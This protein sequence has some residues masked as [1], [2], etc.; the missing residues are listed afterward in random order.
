[1]LRVD[2]D[3]IDLKKLYVLGAW[4]LF[5][6]FYLISV[7]AHWNTLAGYLPLISQVGLDAVLSAL[8]YRLYREYHQSHVSMVY[9]LFLAS[10]ICAMFAD[11]IYH[12]AMNI[13]DINY[14]NRFNSLFEIP[15][16]LFLLFQAIVWLKIFFI[17]SDENVKKIAYLP[18]LTVSTFIFFTFVY[19]IPWE[20]HH[21]SR[22]GMYQL[23]DT[24]LEVIGFAFATLCLARSK[25]SPV[26]YLSIG[27]LFIIS[28]DLLI[29]YEVITGNIPFLN[30]FEMSWC[31]GL[32]MMVYGFYLLKKQQI[33]LLSLNSL[34]SHVA[35]WLINLMLLF[36][37]LFLLAHYFFPQKNISDYLLLVIIPCTFLA[38]IFS[39]Y[40]SSKI[41][42]PLARLEL[43]IKTFM[44][45]G[46]SKFSNA[47]V[48]SP[49]DIEDFILLE[50]FIHDSFQMYKKNQDI[51]MEF[52]NVATQVAHDIQSPMIALNNYLKDAV[53]LEK[54]KYAVVEAS[55]SRINE[56]ANNLL[57]QYKQSDNHFVED[58]NDIDR[59]VVFLNSLIEE[60]RLQFKDKPVE[61]KLTIDR[62]SEAAYVVFNAVSFKR[63]LSNLINNAVE[64]AANHAQIEISLTKKLEHLMLEIRDNGCG[65][66]EDILEDIKLNRA[67]R[68]AKGNGLGL[69]YA[70][71]SIKQWGAHYTIDSKQNLGTIFQIIWPIQSIP[72]W[73]QGD[74]YVH[75]HL[76]IVIVDDDQSVFK[77]WE[78][79]LGDTDCNDVQLIYLSKPDE[80]INYVEGQTD[81]KHHLFLIDYSFNHSELTGLDLIRQCGLENAI[82]VTSQYPDSNIKHSGVKVLLKKDLFSIN[83]QSVHKSVDL[84]LIDDKKIVTD[85]WQIESKKHGKKLVT[86]N[87]SST[88][89]NYTEFFDKHVDV[90]I[91]LNLIDNNGDEVARQLHQL[92]YKKLYIT[93][94]CNIKSL[95]KS[96]WIVEIIDKRP[97]FYKKSREH[98]T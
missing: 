31:F 1:M 12:I 77:S 91:D 37:S 88:F 83:I 57:T 63:T 24:F 38:V 92:G 86:F 59:V 95:S 11:G 76:K 60:K 23:I 94:G 87:D 79:H 17:H 49:T 82:L 39:K 96:P 10:A 93:T 45:E 33:M 6:C 78:K 62:F 70:V 66:S 40:F 22:L 29:R 97:P 58:R 71:K 90:Y 30:A 16:A 26:R 25:N 50:K 32:L 18:Y 44:T 65:I 53:S 69:P 89:M 72:D 15:F 85:V 43:M 8:A 54:S 41:L 46:S 48:C 47:R 67:I 2:S 64:S 34:Q 73:V 98:Q 55:L 7:N 19:S 81:L 36:V 4:F 21:L 27:Y 52:A 35:I 75:D 51:K 13:L 5:S 3:T 56:I 61:I 14:F 28:S 80:L 20:I 9:L 74:I 68:N 42:L 84:V